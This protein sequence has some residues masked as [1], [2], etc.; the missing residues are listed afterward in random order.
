MESRLSRVSALNKTG[1]DTW[2]QAAQIMSDGAEKLARL[3]FDA[4]KTL[5]RESAERG[6][7]MTEVKGLA[8]LPARARKNAAN[9]AG[10]TLSYTR[11]WYDTAQATGVQLFSLASDK[12]A[13]L[14]KGWFEALEDLTDAAPGGKTG[15]TKAAID[16]TRTTVEAVIDGFTRAAKQSIDIADAMIKTTSDSTAQAIH[17]IAS[18]G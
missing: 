11:S 9:T 10:K 2:L 17:A 18:Q 5:V 8:E 1:L 7:D 4:F 12:S 3:Q 14:R 15:G 6:R 13:A 16:S